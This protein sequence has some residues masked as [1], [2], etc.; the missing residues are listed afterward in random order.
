MNMV[1]TT[2]AALAMILAFSSISCVEPGYGNRTWNVMG[3]EAHAEI[4]SAGQESAA[5]FLDEA[6]SSME[7]VDAAMNGSRPD[8][9][10]SEINRQAGGTPFVVDNR[11]LFRCIKLALEYAKRTEG[12]FDPTVGPL[13][14][15][16]GP[17]TGQAG[18]PS[19]AAVEE[20]R[21]R[22][23][24]DKVELFEE[25]QAV[26]FLSPGVELDLGGISPGFAVDVARRN[27]ARTGLRA[28]RL[29]LCGTTYAWGVP[30]E[31]EAWEIAVRS[32]QDRSVILGRLHLR[33]RAI[34]ISGDFAHGWQ[35]PDGSAPVVIDVSR[36]IPADSDV[37]AAAALSDSGKESDALATA[38]HVAGSQR[39]ASILDRSVR[40]EAI[41]LIR[42]GEGPALLLSSSL[43]EVLEIDPAFEEAVGGRIRYILPPGRI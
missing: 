42:T 20:A 10:L 43:R 1:Q 41:L 5:K 29:S 13:M 33:D 22:V 3:G 12:A 39:A 31:A 38:F 4:H 2:G 15:L 14:R 9:L 7:A 19:A 28:G 37:I 40:I 25:S 11:D 23:G 24:W 6:R 18:E 30:P 26:R 16:Y 36:A 8:S 34:S 35:D 17:T 32:F 27:F 21:K